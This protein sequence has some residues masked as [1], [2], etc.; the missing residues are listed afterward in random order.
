MA[1]QR[2]ERIEEIFQS[3]LDLPIEERGAFLDRVCPDPAF[4]AEVDSLLRHFESAEGR[5]LSEP[6]LHPKSNPEPDAFP[7]RI[8]RFRLLR[9]VGEGGMGA[10]FEA[11]QDQ[12]RRRVALKVIRLALA[13]DSLRRRF[14]HEVEILGQLKHP[15]IAQIYEAGTHEDG[16]GTAPYFAMEFIDGVPLLSFLEQNVLD[17]RSRLALMVRICDAVDHAHQRGVIHRDLKPANVLVETAADGSPQPKVLDFGIARAVHAD[18]PSTTMHT[19]VGQI[20]GTLSYMSPEQVAGRTDALDARSDVYSLGLILFEMLARRLPYDLRNRSFVEAG[21]LI[22]DQEPSRLR[23]IDASL[24]GDVETIV[25]KALAKERERRYSTAGEF[26]ED[27]R[28]FLNDEPIRA[29]PASTG[30]QLRKFAQRNKG[31]VGGVA[32]AFGVLLFAVVGVSLALLRATDA[33][34]AAERSAA[35]ATAVSGFL[36]NMLAGVDPEEIGKSALTVKEVLDHASSRLESELTGQPEVAA[37]LE[38]TLGR[39]YSTL[40][41][42]FDADR[43]LRRAVE[44]RRQMTT[45]DDHDLADMLFDLAANLQEKRD[46]AAAESPTREALD[47]R[48][49]LLGSDHPK[50]ADSLYDLGS[51]YI[52][53]QRAAAAEPLIRESL[54]IRRRNLG[55]ESAAAATSES[56]LGWCLMSLGRL[57]EAESAMRDAVEMVRRL[58]GDHEKALAARLTFLSDVLRVQNKWVDARDADLEAVE[59][60]TRRLPPDHPSLAWN[61]LCLARA[62]FHLGELDQADIEG[63]QALEIY[64]KKRGDPHT[65]IADTQHL[66]A[67]IADARGRFSEA[68]SWW[69]ACIEMRRRL[70][71]AGHAELVGAETGL[72]QCVTARNNA[73]TGFTP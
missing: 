9:K 53:T 44:L 39:H 8:G 37:S 7:R 12:P 38:Q 70:F 23:S 40:G 33:R 55:T 29:R 6:L 41:Y 11:E 59:I 3:A 42:Y 31:L 57:D 26:A 52:E 68:E 72:A 60:R 54:E 73:S 25:Q 4:R 50:V 34:Q 2:M 10:V 47:M 35:T 45:G 66:M 1:D 61:L 67:Q 65:D 32:V 51:I 71:P 5:F 24:R 18:D 27:L 62:R 56:L 49:R 28:R 17:V 48:R 14:A 21:N 20:L 36:Q 63:R 69:R 19:E 46:I 58:P 15:G 43:H 30:Y 64:R 16:S 22:R 13:S